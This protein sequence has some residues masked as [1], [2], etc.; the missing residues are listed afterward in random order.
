MSDETENFLNLLISGKKGLTQEVDRFSNRSFQKFWSNWTLP[1]WISPRH[2]PQVCLRSWAEFNLALRQ[3][4]GCRW[5]SAMKTFI[6]ILSADA[7]YSSKTI[8]SYVTGE[9]VENFAFHVNLSTS[10]IR[11]Q[12]RREPTRT[13]RSML[14]VVS[15][16]YIAGRCNMRTRLYP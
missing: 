1:A 7:T 10:A 6:R 15:G 3:A 13:D 16:D 5:S 2:C 9:M 4:D 14:S 11:S 8:W 12:T